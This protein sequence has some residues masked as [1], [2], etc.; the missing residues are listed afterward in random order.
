VLSRTLTVLYAATHGTLAAAYRSQG[1]LPFEL[2]PPAPVVPPEL[3]LPPEPGR[4][5]APDVPALPP[6]PAPVTPPELAAPPELV[7]PPEPVTPPEAVT[8]PE[9]VTPPV[10]ARPP[11]P[12]VP[13]L[14]PSPAPPVEFPPEL[15]A[16][17]PPLPLDPSE[18]GEHAIPRNPSNVIKMPSGI[19]RAM[20]ASW[21]RSRCG[22]REQ[23]RTLSTFLLPGGQ[24]CQEKFS[25]V[26]AQVVG[27]ELEKS[28][29]MRT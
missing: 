22:S 19:R 1:P 29:A 14:C 18:E 16:S 2:E 21:S 13:P 11:V 8:P 5:A 6:V 12:V 4:P 7:A 25:P 23:R 28:A 27:A 17:F 24:T 9:L 26:R 10:E 15:A 20:R 3:E